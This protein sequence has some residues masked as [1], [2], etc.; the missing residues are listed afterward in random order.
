MLVSEVYEVRFGVLKVWNDVFAN[1]DR[2]IFLN[3]LP[4]QPDVPCQFSAAI[5][6]P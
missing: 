2:I 4:V 1:W 5:L 3:I 6:S